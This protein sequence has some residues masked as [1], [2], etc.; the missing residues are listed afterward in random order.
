MSKG[1]IGLVVLD[2]GNPFFAEVARGSDAAVTEAGYVLLLASSRGSADREA[3]LLDDLEDLGVDG[4][5]VTP[6]DASPEHMTQ[7]RERQT[8]VV[9]VD[10][11]S[12]DNS[13]S[14]V[15]VDNEAGGALAGQ[16]LVSRGHERIAFLT[17]P[18]SIQVLA[19]RRA[20][21]VSALEDAGL[22]PEVALED[23]VVPGTNAVEGQRAVDRVLASAPTAVL[24]AND[25][26]ALGLLRA[27][28]E[29]GVSVPDDVAVMGYDDVEFAHALQTPLSTIRQPKYEMG[30]EAAQI[31]LT[32]LTR[33]YGRP[34]HV[35]FDPQLVVRESTG[36]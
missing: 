24:C 9:L 27:F 1:T 15:A 29:R 14:S 13:I 20:G 11:H 18:P 36:A 19:E 21:L 7:L 22:D 3:E 30:R 32:H 16:H 33:G 34:K 8:P 10:S 4:L 5:M 17:G 12:P 31:L 35:T 2:A 26:L 25:L 28:A 6:A 23:V